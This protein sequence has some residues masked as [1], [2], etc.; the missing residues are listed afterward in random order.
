[1]QNKKLLNLAQKIKELTPHRVTISTAESCTGGMVSSYLTNIAGSSEYFL[2][3]VISYSNEVKIGL[4]SVSQNTLDKFGAVSEETA[5]EM[6]T[7]SRGATGSDIAVSVT[8][9]AGPGGGSKEKP[10]GT[11]CFAIA[12]NLGVRSMTHHFQGSREE[13]R[14]SSCLVALELIL[15][16]IQ[17]IHPK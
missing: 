10:V 5:I 15:D 16:E 6:A 11:V 8:G 12:N 3:G 2:G 14:E 17:K 4:L 9:I 13:V 7:G 1:M